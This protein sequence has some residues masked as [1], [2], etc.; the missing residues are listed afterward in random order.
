MRRRSSWITG[1]C[2]VVV[3]A[4]AG[5]GCS[6]SSSNSEQAQ[7]PNIVMIYTDDLD[8]TLLDA[9][10]QLFPNYRSLVEHGTTFRNSFVVDSLCCPSRA[11]MLRGQYDHNTGVLGNSPPHG[12]FERF[13]ALKRERST[14]ATW[15]HDAGYA[16]GFFGKYLNGY[17]HTAGSKYVPPGWDDWVS[18]SSGTPYQEYNY[19]LNVNG[20]QERHGDAPDDYMVDILGDHGVEFIERYAG[21]KPMFAV[22]STY[23]PHLPATPAPRYKGSVPGLRAPRTPSFDEADISDKPAFVR[24]QKLLSDK[25]ISALDGIYQNQVESMRAVDDVIGRVVDKLRATKQLDETYVIFASDN[26]YHLGDHRL[27]AGKLTAYEQDI[28]VPFV[29]RGPGVPAGRSVD[30]MVANTDLAPT[31]AALAGVKAPSFVDGRSIVPLLHGKTP[32]QWRQVVLVERSDADVRLAIT[33]ALRAATTTTTAPSQTR[34]APTGST[35][36]TSTTALENP[37]E[38]EPV[39]N[40]GDNAS[41]IIG[42]TPGYKALRSVDQLYVEWDSGERELYDLR[43]DPHELDNLASAAPP[44]LLDALHDRLVTLT[45]CKGES[46]RRA[47]NAPAPR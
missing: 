23:A 40:E 39:G 20:R 37:D 26:G 16:T 28:R 46:C 8:A 3:I 17:P 10:L 1:A 19:V 35:T 4:L 32:D 15:V 6:G 2:L 47:E 31:F 42:F 45:H 38:P 33:K 14:I 34:S 36:T 43:K 44:T 13:Y 9:N 41:L 5:S 22:V 12:G 24:D 21:K 29:V 27:R 30:A 18:P 11:T 7:R 25:E